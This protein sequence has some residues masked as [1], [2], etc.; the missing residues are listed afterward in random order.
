MRKLF[1]VLFLLGGYLS[2]YA[3]IGIGTR[4]PSSSALLDVRSTAGNKGVLMPKVALISKQSYA[5]ITG[6]SSDEHNLGLIVYNTTTDHAKE[7][8]PGYYYWTGSS[9]TALLHTEAL[10]DLIGQQD[11]KDGVYYGKINGGVQAVLYVKKKTADGTEVHE[12]INLLSLLLQDISNLSEEHIHQLRKTLG[13]DITEQAVYT[14]KSI[15][16]KH[17]YS[18]YGRTEIEEGNAE[19]R[20]VRLSRET[21]QLLEEGVVF[22]IH[23]LNAHQQII[24]INTT[25]VEITSNGILKFSLGSSSMYYTLPAGEYGVIVDLLSSREQPTRGL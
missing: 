17:H 15:Q 11:S 18:V 4:T 21:L 12:E 1:F 6:S 9:W 19:V 2:G 25:D 10:F 16:G 5:P 14:G 20:G 7:L 8:V 24:D 23:L 13:Y 22:D 3:Q